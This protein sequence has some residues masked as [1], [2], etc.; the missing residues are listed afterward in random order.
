MRKFRPLLIALPS[1][2]LAMMYGQTRVFFVM[3]RDGLLPSALAKVHPKF[4][5]PH[6]VTI[7]TG[8]FVTVAAAFVPDAP[9]FEAAFL[10][11]VPFRPAVFLPPA[12]RA[13]SFENRLPRF[14]E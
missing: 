13:T 1:V 2:V 11:G 3:A 12:L 10:P 9:F 14:V 4:R 5:T 6:V 7:V 8:A